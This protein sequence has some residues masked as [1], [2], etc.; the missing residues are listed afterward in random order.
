MWFGPGWTECHN[1]S[2]KV[3]WVLVRTCEPDCGT[4]P[5]WT[6]FSYNVG[7]GNHVFFGRFSV[8]KEM[9]PTVL[10]NIL[11]PLQFHFTQET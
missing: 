7:F 3:M 11:T 4:L 1:L 2:G 6:C 9:A 5:D 10:M 8:W